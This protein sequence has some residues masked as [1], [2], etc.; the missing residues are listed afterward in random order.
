MTGVLR[1]IQ[2]HAHINN[3][4]AFTNNL[5]IKTNQNQREYINGKNGSVAKK[6]KEIKN[7]L[8]SIISKSFQNLLKCQKYNETFITRANHSE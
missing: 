2:E 3:L 5:L 8:F 6:K 4:A 7:L 1:E